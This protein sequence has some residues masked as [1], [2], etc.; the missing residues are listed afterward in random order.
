ML[1]F[2]FPKF[3]SLGAIA[4][5]FGTVGDEEEGA[6]LVVLD[7]ALEDAALGGG[8]EGGGGFV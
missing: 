6:P 5:N 2:L 4:E 1:A 8:I 7:D 3:Q